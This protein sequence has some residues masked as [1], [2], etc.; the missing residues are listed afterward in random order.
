MIRDSA[1]LVYPALGALYQ[2]AKVRDTLTGEA[3]YCVAVIRSEAP[4]WPDYYPDSKQRLVVSRLLRTRH[5]DVLGPHWKV[6]P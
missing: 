5:P 6:H 2:S 3:T 4:E 1:D